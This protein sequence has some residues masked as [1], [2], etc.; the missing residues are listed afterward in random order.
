MIETFSEIRKLHYK[1]L[2]QS[3]WPH[4]QTVKQ[5]VQVLIFVNIKTAFSIPVS[6]DLVEQPDKLAVSKFN[7]NAFNRLSVLSYVEYFTDLVFI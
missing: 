3:Q 4:V 2:L 5:K 1:Q 7:Q 6:L